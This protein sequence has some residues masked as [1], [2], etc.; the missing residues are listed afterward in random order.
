MIL[1][2][3]NT[4]EP[5]KLIV[6]EGEDGFTIELP[7]QKSLYTYMEL[8]LIYMSCFD[9]LKSKMNNAIQRN[10][11]DE[12]QADYFN[13]NPFR[14]KI[15]EFLFDQIVSCSSLKQTM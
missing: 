9:D 10:E 4:E 14:N 6:N 7:R 1:A 3:A 15:R 11:V 8:R 13:K 5:A 2:A 12:M